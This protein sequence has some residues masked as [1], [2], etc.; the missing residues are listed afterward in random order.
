MLDLLKLYHHKV[1]CAMSDGTEFVLGAPYGVEFVKVV[2]QTR[3]FDDIEQAFQE[4]GT[5][6]RE[7]ITRGLSVQVKPEQMTEEL[8]SYTIIE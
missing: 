7:L 4:M 1:V 2:A 8:I 5:A 6:S 3:Q